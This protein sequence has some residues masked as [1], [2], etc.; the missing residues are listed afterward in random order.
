MDE[1]KAEIGKLKRETDD[2]IKKLK[3][4]SSNEINIDNFHGDFVKLPEF[5]TQYKIAAEANDWNDRDKAKKFPVYLRGLAL[6]AYQNIPNADRNDWAKVEEQF[7]KNILTDDVSMLY[8]RK[9][10]TRKQK[11][12]ETIAEYAYELK[13]LAKRAFPELKDEQLDCYLMDQFLDGVHADMQDILLDKEYKTYND[14]MKKAQTIEYRRELLATPQ[15]NNF[16]INKNELNSNKDTSNFSNKNTDFKQYYQKI[17]DK[18]NY[19]CENCK[20]YG[21]LTNSCRKL[22]N[23]RPSR[24]NF[25]YRGNQNRNYGGNNFNN[26][27][28]NDS[29]LRGSYNFNKSVNFNNFRNNRSRQNAGYY[30][31]NEQ[32]FNSPY[33]QDNSSFRNRNYRNNSPYRYNNSRSNSPYRNNYYQQN[34]YRNNDYRS[35][36]SNYRNNSPYRGAEY[37]N[38]NYNRNYDSRDK[39]PVR[40]VTFKNDNNFKDKQFKEKNEY[41]CQLEEE[42]DSLKVCDERN[43]YRDSSV[44]INNTKDI[45]RLNNIINECFKI[46]KNDKEQLEKIKTEIKILRKENDRKNDDND[47]NKVEMFDFS[48]QCDDNKLERLNKRLK[49]PKDKDKLK[50]RS[51]NSFYRFN[52]T[53]FISL[54]LIIMI[55]RVNTTEAI[56]A[57]DCSKPEFGN[58]YSLFDVEQCPEASPTRLIQSEDTYNIYQETTIVSVIVI[59]CKLRSAELLLYCGHLSHSSIVKTQV[60]DLSEELTEEQCRD[61]GHIG[62]VKLSPDTT[63]KVQINSTTRQN[64]MIKGTVSRDGSCTGETY[65]IDGQITKNIVVSREYEITITKYSANFDSQ[66]GVMLTNG[67][68]MCQ[69]EHSSCRTGFSTLTYKYIAPICQLI[70]LKSVLLLE[71]QGKQTNLM[72]EEK[73]S[74]SGYGSFSNATKIEKI[75]ETDTPLVLMSRDDDILRFIRKESKIKCNKKVYVTNYDN[76]YVSKHRLA[77]AQTNVKPVDLRQYYYFNNKIDYTYH[78]LLNKLE[79]VYHETVKRDCLLHREVLRTKLTMAITN[80]DIATPLLSAEIGLFARTVGEVLYT[81]RCKPVLVTLRQEPDRC[82]N[83]LPVIFQNQNLYLEPVTRM[84]TKNPTIIKCTRALAPK[85]QINGKVWISL[86]EQKPVTV[87]LTLELPK[88][89]E[90]LQ[91]NDIQNLAKKGLYTNAALEEASKYILFP[92]ERARIMTLIARQSTKDLQN[93]P[94]FELLL[95]P[96]HFKKATASYLKMVWGKFLFFGQIFSGFMGIYI[97]FTALKMLTQQLLSTYTLYK[98]FGITWKLTLGC[99]PFLSK[100]LLIKH[101]HN[102]VSKYQKNSNN[103]YGNDNNDDNEDRRT[104]NSID[105]NDILKENLILEVK[106]RNAETQSCADFNME[107]RVKPPIKPKPRMRPS[108]PSYSSDNESNEKLLDESKSLYPHL[109]CYALFNDNHITPKIKIKVNGIL[110]DALIDTG[111]TVTLL[112]AKHVDFSKEELRNTNVRPSSASGHF[113]D[114]IGITDC[115]F[116]FFDE[117]IQT[118]TLVA[119]ELQTGVL[120]GMDILS[121]LTNKYIDLKSGMIISINRDEL[122]EA[123]KIREVSVI[124]KKDFKIPSW[125]EKILFVDVPFCRTEEV[126]FEPSKSF[127]SKYIVPVSTNVS[128]PTDSTI[129]IRMVNLS[130]SDIVIKENT[131]LGTASNI[132]M[133]VKHINNETP[134]KLPFF[135]FEKSKIN[136]EEKNDLYNLLKKYKTVFAQSE[137]D[138][139][140]TNVLKHTIPLESNVPIKQHPYRMEYA[141]REESN[142]QIQGM[143]ENHIIQPSFSPWMSPVVMVKKKDGTMRFCIDYRKLNAVTIKDTYPLPRIDE[144]L[145]KLHNA[146]FFTSMDL[147]SGFWQIEIEEEDKY[148]TAFSTGDGLYE[149]NVL[150]FGLTGSPPTFQR[151][152][153]IILMDAKHAMVY[154]DDILIYSTTFKQHLKDIEVVLNRL[155]NAGLKLKPSKC[156][157]AKESISFLGHIISSNGIQPDPKN[158]EKVSDT[159]PPKNVKEVQRFLGLASYYRRF[160][161]NFAKVV[162]PMHEL[163]QKHIKFEWSDKCQIAF[164]QIKHELINPPILKFPDFEKPFLIM[165][166]AS[167]YAIGAVLSQNDKNGKDHPIAYASRSL[168]SH[169]KNYSTIEREALALVFATK[170]FRHYIWSKEIILL[171]D[172]KPLQWLMSHKDTSSRLIR[173]ALNLQDLNIRIQYRSGKSNA[174]ADFLSRIEEPIVATVFQA[175]PLDDKLKIEQDNDDEI[176]IIKQFL[177]N[178]IVPEDTPKLLASHLSKDGFRYNKKK[179]I[180]YYRQNKDNL[181]VIP[182]EF[183]NTLLLQYHDGCLGGHLSSRKVISKMI[184]KYFWPNILND[185]KTW[186]KNCKICASRKNTLRNQI[187]PLKPIKPP[188]APMEITALDIVGPLPL[189]IYGNKY[190]LVFCDYLTKWPEAVAI[191]DQKAETVARVFVE[192]IIF[193]YGAPKK[194]ITDQGT[195]FM[196]DLMKCICDIFDIIKLNTSPYHP[197][198]DGL[199]E[200]F[201]GT[202]LNMLASYSSSNQTDWDIHIPSCLFA[203]RTAVHPA[204]KETPFFLMYG[205]DTFLPIDHLF[206]KQTTHLQDDPNYKD[207]IIEQISQAWN[208][209]RQNI[210]FSQESYKEYYD[211]KSKPPSYSVGDRV[212]LFTVLNKKGKTHK[213]H[214]PYQGPYRVIEVKEPD[215]KIISIFKPNSEPIIVH[216]NRCRHAPPEN[217][218]FEQIK[219]NNEQVVKDTSYNLRPRVN[220]IL[221]KYKDVEIKRLVHFIGSHNE[222]NNNVIDIEFDGHSTTALLDTGSPIS[223]VPSTFLSDNEINSLINTNDRYYTITNEPLRI[224]GK[225]GL[226]MAINDETKKYKTFNVVDCHINYIIFGTDMINEMTKNR[227]NLINVQDKNIIK[228][229]KPT[230]NPNVSIISERSRISQ[231]IFEN[232]FKSC[233]IILWILIFFALIKVSFG[234]IVNDSIADI[235]TLDPDIKYGNLLDHWR[236]CCLYCITFEKCHKNCKAYSYHQFI[237]LTYATKRIPQ[238]MK[239]LRKCNEHTITSTTAFIMNNITSHLIKISNEKFWIFVEIIVKVT[240]LLIASLLILVVLP[241]MYWKKKNI[242]FKRLNSKYSRPPSYRPC[243]YPSDNVSINIDYPLNEFRFSQISINRSNNCGINRSNDVPLLSTFKKPRHLPISELNSNTSSNK[244]T[245]ADNPE[246][247]YSTDEDS[248]SRSKNSS[249][250]E[251]V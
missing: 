123:K 189:T 197:Q 161:K 21:H 135:S 148:K 63:I 48:Q 1:I 248:E 41:I 185:I 246:Y 31:N 120:L 103:H 23:I 208:I 202:L 129:P 178:G 213:L 138:L 115:C 10:K 200:R 102:I 210:L 99:C 40:T 158:T 159:Q 81:F 98:I 66:T 199:V 234:S 221:N 146:K 227:V 182:N 190:I 60:L 169:E 157:W 224:H 204:T 132:D 109:N 141:N 144:M 139:G 162:H 15:Q 30:R 95:S 67:Y 156:E 205:R 229:T 84:I 198:T 237:L 72:S 33:R 196:S 225:I 183:R 223:I 176:K 239:C 56:K 38:K 57:F 166:D 25:N 75:P 68:T 35:R 201:N 230:I 73:I 170:Y 29:N 242:I 191:P 212:L 126:I 207:V 108:A 134:K 36:G 97:V 13:K 117:K 51:N 217:L 26:Y 106:K 76:I 140:R 27:N 233:K 64:I 142:R 150:P 228:L 17:D 119:R 220:K 145:D 163:L 9:F 7:K 94:D 165:T 89:T 24:A 93:N 80:P 244:L 147:Q 50:E 42:I 181:L 79:T 193:N 128:I 110:T 149:F 14:L 43:H 251:V 168:K 133:I 54:F 236:K 167:N 52:F 46:I 112:N 203:Y 39:S 87:P 247:T 216:M 77:D 16:T 82:T 151:C 222:I 155:K 214:R 179:N 61:A 78:R 215:L 136:S 6:E 105:S 28:K 83:E 180:L 240:V 91:F 58:E 62:Q 174:N 243:Y 65:K 206:L 107:E 4:K 34:T 18:M 55:L 226:Q 47:N 137:Y 194:L 173:W 231:N 192:K 116:E 70:F 187:V 2:E 184:T 118:E 22:I 186:C 114:I 131:K 235:E 209:A 3:K 90:V 49:Y 85:F 143:L 175:M 121:K 241:V 5:L 101:C 211:R 88:V 160:I 154:I 152:M 19:Y 164:E 44:E 127:M 59:E 12:D 250:Y 195:N 177:D 171:T 188:K 153:N 172:H 32:R 249:I 238:S 37:F 8:S 232:Y 20:R 111:A 74:P 124:N 122:K 245:M 11:P 218:Q 104:I 219:N 96:E 53:N 86:P 125:S 113:I 69:L 92:R 71:L 130:D 100:L 45:S